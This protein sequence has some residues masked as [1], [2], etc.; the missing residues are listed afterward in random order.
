[1]IKSSWFLHIFVQ[2]KFSSAINM[3]RKG[4]IKSFPCSGLLLPF[5]E[6]MK[7]SLGNFLFTGLF[8]GELITPAFT[9][10]L[11]FCQ[12]H[13]Q[14]AANLTFCLILPA[15]KVPWWFFGVQFSNNT[16]CRAA[17]AYQGLFIIVHQKRLYQCILN[18]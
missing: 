2:I 8:Y 4:C 11:Y 5:Y 6:L 13:T 17:K 9:I 15:A 10:Y 12:K 7:L 1:M 3:Q 18:R 14:K 16:T